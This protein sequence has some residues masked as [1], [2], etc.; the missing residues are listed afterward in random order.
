GKGLLDLSRQHVRAT[1]RVAGARVDVREDVRERGGG[2]HGQA[3]GLLVGAAREG[4][5]GQDGGGDGEGRGQ[6]RR[7][8]A[9]SHA[10][11]ITEV[12]LTTA[13]AAIPGFSPSSSTA[14]RVT[15]ATT[16]AGSVTVSSTW[17]SR[18]ST[19]TSVTV[20]RGR[21]RALM[22]C[23]PWT[24]RSRSISSSVTS[25]RFAL[26]RSVRIRPSRSHRRSVSTL[27]PSSRAASVAVYACFGIGGSI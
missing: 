7:E 21:L 14:S 9:G 11:T 10:S 13:V 26:S 17:A 19:R 12:D 1:E 27:I 22:W 6:R 5:R 8:R 23:A 3:R 20:P 25:R 18:P 4:D 15:T 24:P 16:R 2:E